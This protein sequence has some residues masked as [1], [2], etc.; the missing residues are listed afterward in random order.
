MLLHHVS[1]NY[2]A[3]KKENHILVDIW[4]TPLIVDLNSIFGNYP[5]RSYHCFVAT[6]KAGSAAFASLISCKYPNKIIE[7]EKVISSGLKQHYER[8]ISSSTLLTAAVLTRDL[9]YSSAK[10]PPCLTHTFF[11]RTERRKVFFMKW[12]SQAESPSSFVLALWLHCLR[13]KNQQ[14]MNWP[15]F[16]MYKEF[17]CEKS[18]DR[19]NLLEG[20]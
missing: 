16:L 17:Y 20:C 10:Q 12:K 11:C 9:Q 18:N 8:K 14:Q 5:A 4:S 19:T 15:I 1:E 2:E 7:R 13:S 3:C 6:G